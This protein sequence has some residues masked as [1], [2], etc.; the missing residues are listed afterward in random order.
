MTGRLPSSSRANPLPTPSRVPTGRRGPSSSPSCRGWWDRWP[1]GQAGST[2]RQACGRGP[3]AAGCG[4]RWPGWRHDGD[5]FGRRRRRNGRIPAGRC[6]LQRNVWVSD[7]V[8]A[9]TQCAA[10]AAAA[11]AA[12]LAG[13]NQ[14]G[15]GTQATGVASG[16]AV[17]AWMS[18]ETQACCMSVENCFQAG[19]V[20]TPGRC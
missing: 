3:A 14:D 18:V 8:C 2:G 15:Q 1:G 20:Q 4:T 7:V 10:A 6:H 16:H 19:A 13:L 9:A 17:W 5:S 12:A 11:A